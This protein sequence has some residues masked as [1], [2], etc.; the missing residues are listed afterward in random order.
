MNDFAKTRQ[1]PTLSFE[2]GVARGREALYCDLNAGAQDKT[3]PWK[4]KSSP[5]DSYGLEVQPS[6]ASGGSP[7]PRNLTGMAATF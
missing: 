1:K 2:C 5:V 3:L 7:G 6:V 4:R